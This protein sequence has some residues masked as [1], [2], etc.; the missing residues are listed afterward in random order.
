[1]T[2]G[3]FVNVSRP[4]G[5]GPYACPCCGYLTLDERGGY[6]LC[7]VC[8]WEDD[9]QDQH[10]ADEVR[11]GPNGK[12]SL[13]AARRNFANLGASS[14]KRLAN[15]RAPRDEEHPLAHG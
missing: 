6:E 12:L 9:G 7:P 5:G 11:G 15:V 3:K 2:E 10:D 13:T 1:M 8:F 4:L 14:E